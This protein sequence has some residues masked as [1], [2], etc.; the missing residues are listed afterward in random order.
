MRNLGKPSENA[1]LMGVNGD[2]YPLKT[3]C[4][5]ISSISSSDKGILTSPTHRYLF[6]EYFNFNRNSCYVPVVRLLEIPW[7]SWLDFSRKAIRLDTPSGV[8]T[9]R[10]DSCAVRVDDDSHR[11]LARRFPSA[12]RRAP[13]G[14]RLHVMGKLTM[15]IT[16]FNSKLL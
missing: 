8:Q 7:V 15:S 14:R 2:Q 9:L 1:G 6:F 4:L 13:S 3:Y 5:V 16:I 12:L 10:E 11:S